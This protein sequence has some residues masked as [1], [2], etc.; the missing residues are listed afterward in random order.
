MTSFSAAVINVN[1][2]LYSF[3][4]VLEFVSFQRDVYLSKVSLQMALLS[5]RL[6]LFRH[7]NG[8]S[9]ESSLECSS[10]DRK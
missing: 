4:E 5:F 7:S 9:A 2:V 10:R 1:E 6:H 8:L 3:E